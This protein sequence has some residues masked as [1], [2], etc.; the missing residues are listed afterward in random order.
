M[1]S[2]EKL[3]SAENPSTIELP[4]AAAGESRLRITIP[5]KPTAALPVFDKTRHKLW[6]TTTAS[7]EEAEKERFLPSPNWPLPSSNVVVGQFRR[8]NYVQGNKGI[9]LDEN[10]PF[11]GLLRVKS[12][13]KH[14]RP[15]SDVPDVPRLP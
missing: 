4:P 2:T 6:A 8:D 9:E 5:P 15:V 3:W 14:L 13:R 11:R 7:D 10:S 1:P 12:L